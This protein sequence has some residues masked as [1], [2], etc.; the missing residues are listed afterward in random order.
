MDTEKRRLRML[1]R[2]VPKGCKLVSLLLVLVIVFS[3][4]GGTEVERYLKKY[5]KP[6][7]FE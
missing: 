2:W 4:C 7:D 6:V 3:G 1:N 5:A